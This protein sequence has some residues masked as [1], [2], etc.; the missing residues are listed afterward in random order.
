MTKKKKQQLFMSQTTLGHGFVPVNGK[1]WLVYLLFIAL[2]FT[3]IAIVA[4]VPSLVAEALV[5]LCLIAGLV[6]FVLVL[7]RHSKTN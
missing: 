2:V 4:A 5:L 7:L 3:G 1:G 6:A